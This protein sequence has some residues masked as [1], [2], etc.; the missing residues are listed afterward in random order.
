MKENCQK[1][2][3]LK[4][5]LTEADYSQKQSKKVLANPLSPKKTL[6]IVVCPQK[7]FGL[8]DFG[9]PQGL[10]MGPKI[11]AIGKK[12]GIV[13]VQCEGIIRHIFS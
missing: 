13:C 4:I 11:F 8:V 12:C 9:V 5:S 1:P 7:G 2:W 10:N 6:L 3:R